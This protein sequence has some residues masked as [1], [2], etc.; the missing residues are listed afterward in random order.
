VAKVIVVDDGSIDGTPELAAQ[1]GARVVT[2]TLLGKG[3]SME[4]GVW[5]AQNE[6]VVFLDGDLNGLPELP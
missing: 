3:A 6:I 2:S 1:A 4:D 5:A